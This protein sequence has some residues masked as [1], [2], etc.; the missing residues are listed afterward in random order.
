MTSQLDNHPLRIWEVVADLPEECLNPEVEADLRRWL[1]VR[2]LLL[3]PE[4]SK[5]LKSQPRAWETL[6]KR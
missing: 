1:A 6:P 3:S 2:Y 4:D 5:V